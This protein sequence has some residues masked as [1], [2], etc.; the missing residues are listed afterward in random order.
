MTAVS[1][2]R[3]TNGATPS[4]AGYG[5]DIPVVAT[6]AIDN[7]MAVALVMADDE[8]ITA[9]PFDTDT[10]A[11]G[12]PMAVALES[13]AVGGT[14]QVRVFGPA[15]VQTPATGPSIGEVVI[16]TTTAGVADGL[17]ADATSIVGRSHGYFMTDEIGTTNT[18]WA[19]ITG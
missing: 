4:Y 19:F 6:T 5:I 17:A 9:V 14:G 13:I 12:Y 7:K 11:T 3:G 8:T 18:C 15:I 10:H 1:D 2:P 16:G